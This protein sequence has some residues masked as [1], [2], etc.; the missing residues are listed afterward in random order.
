MDKRKLRNTKS[1]TPGLPGR[2]RREVSAGGLIWRRGP[3]EK[4]IEIVLVRPAGKDTWV[5]PKGHVEPGEGVIEAAL[6]ETTEESGLEVEAGDPLG[7]ISYI[8]S[9]RDR[10]GETPIRISKRVHFY[11]MEPRGGDT[12]R[13]DAEI[14]EVQWVPLEEALRRASHKS[15]RELIMKARTMLNAATR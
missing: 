11:L 7:E 15:E 1:G 13:H 3:R 4:G 2:I 8:Y 12:S 9:W 10:P 14:D 5:L 6:R